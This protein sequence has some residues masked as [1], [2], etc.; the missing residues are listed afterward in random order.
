MQRQNLWHMY[1]LAIQE[2]TMRIVLKLER[3]RTEVSEESVSY[4]IKTR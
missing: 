2:A 3:N 4:V 1:L